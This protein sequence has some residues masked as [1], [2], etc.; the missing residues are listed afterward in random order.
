VT[1]RIA[2]PAVVAGAGFTYHHELPQDIKDYLA[3]VPIVTDAQAKELTA[4]VRMMDANETLQEYADQFWNDGGEPD[5]VKM[6]GPVCGSGIGSEVGLA[7]DPS[8]LSSSEMNVQAMAS[9]DKKTTPKKT[10]L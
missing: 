5:E 8:R 3:T 10:T 6:G 2:A 7:T 1:P 9:A 4:S